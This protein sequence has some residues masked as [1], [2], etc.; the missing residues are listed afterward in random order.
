MS[1]LIATV[2]T[3]RRMFV[4]FQYFVFR[5][6]AQF[7]N[8]FLLDLSDALAGEAVLVADFLECN[9]RL[10]DAVEGLDDVALAFR[11]HLQG[12]G[13]LFAQRFA[14]QFVVGFGRVVVGQHVEQAAAL[15]VVERSIHRHVASALLH[16][17][18]NFLLGQVNL[19]GNLVDV[20]PAFVL[21]LKLVEHLVD[22]VVGAHLVERH[23]HDAALLGNGL[24]NALA[25]P[26]HGIGD[27]LET[28]GL[29]ESFGSLDES[30]VALVDEVGEAHTLILILLGHRNNK[31][32]IGFRETFQSLT[33]ALPDALRQ[34]HFFFGSQQFLMTD[35]LQ[36][37][38]ER[39]IFAIGNRFCNFQLSH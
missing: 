8:S 17:H 33:V 5:V 4:C 19:V 15:V 20:G 10:I 22:L 28:S 13:N 25:N 35:F 34:F 31:A 36:V 1:E 6:L 24:Q 14:Q 30:H 39:S 11:E 37:L 38:V 32:Q 16:G 2:M 23:F 3:A 21:L 29:I 9:L 7:A 12:V 27:K 26:P 18:L